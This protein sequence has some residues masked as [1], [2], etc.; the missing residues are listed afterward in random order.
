M[1]TPA[2]LL[3]PT[4]TGVLEPVLSQS[5][6]N[7]GRSGHK[8][9][10]SE[11][12]TNPAAGA[13]Y[14]S[15][16]GRTG[17]PSVGIFRPSPAQT[18]AIVI[19]DTT[20]ANRATELWLLWTRSPSDN[21]ISSMWFCSLGVG[22]WKATYSESGYLIKIRT[23]FHW[24][25]FERNNKKAKKIGRFKEQPTEIPISENKAKGIWKYVRHLVSY[26]TFSEERLAMFVSMQLIRNRSC[27]AGYFSA[28][29]IT[30]SNFLNEK[31]HA[32]GMRDTVS[33]G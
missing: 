15:A 10:F 12:P 17:R 24:M 22:C 16:A 18:W 29:Q 19:G 7:T 4:V 32:K 6:F 11:S 3:S 26:W 23:G 20:R 31:S 8:L 2:H 28:T 33:K 21:G 30:H 13:S 9:R 1:L 14:V 25:E 5:A 27:N